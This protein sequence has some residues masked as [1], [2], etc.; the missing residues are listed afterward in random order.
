MSIL[1]IQYVDLTV[2]PAGNSPYDE[3]IV[4]CDGGIVTHIIGGFRPRLVLQDPNDPAGWGGIQVKGWNGGD[5]FAGIGVGDLVSLSDVLV[6][7][8]RGNTFL[9]VGGSLA[10]DAVVTV[11]SFGNPLPSPKL[12]TLD[13]IPAPLEDL[14]NPGDWYVEDHRAEKYEAMLLVVEDVTVTTMGL[15]KADDNYNLHNA[16]GDAWATD[17]AASPADL[18]GDY[19]P[20]IEL[21][22]QFDR[23][24]G[25]LEQYTNEG[26]DYYQLLTRGSR[27]VPEPSA[28]VLL[29]TGLALVGS[30][31]RR[32]RPW[33]RMLRR[34]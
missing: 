12:V 24:V 21:G 9:Q 34:S 16:S 11:E 18:V 19:L 7:E 5:T 15:G 30:A 32:R 4:D 13:E 3:Q 33:R 6:E 26:W 20:P 27:D 22:A 23:V 10:P 31:W 29:L 1:D 8:Y 17:Y 14:E 28:L 2:D 25:V